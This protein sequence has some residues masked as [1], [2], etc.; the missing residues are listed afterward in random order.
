VITSDVQDDVLNRLKTAVT[1]LTHKINEI[2]YSWYLYRIPG[3]NLGL[4]L[5]SGQL[6][7]GRVLVRTCHFQA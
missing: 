6:S 5:I 2:K 7:L 4:Q 1:Y 3:I